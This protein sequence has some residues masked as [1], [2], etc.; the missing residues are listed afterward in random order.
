[1]AQ[2]SKPSEEI[3]GSVSIEFEGKTYNGGFTVRDRW[4]R[5]REPAYIECFASL[6]PYLR[7]QLVSNR[8]VR[9]I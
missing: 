2:E 5:A 3:R 9:R 7:E 6:D 1:M 8:L 4:L